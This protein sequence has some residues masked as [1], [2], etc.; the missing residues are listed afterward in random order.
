MSNHERPD[1]DGSLTRLISP[2]RLSP[3]LDLASGSESSALDLYVANLDQFTWPIWINLRA[4][5]D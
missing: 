1:G 5:T 4:S 3:Y 2:A